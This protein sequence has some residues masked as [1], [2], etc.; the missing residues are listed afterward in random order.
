M[1]LHTAQAEKILHIFQEL[2]AS[3]INEVIDFA[4]YLKS[5]ERKS[6]KKVKRKTVA[7]VPAY[8]LGAMKETACDRDELYGEYL[9]TKLA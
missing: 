6:G 1:Q 5:R 8:H 3:K 4:E 2:P 7:R 9:A